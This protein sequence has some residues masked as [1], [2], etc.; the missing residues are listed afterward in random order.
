MFGQNIQ[1]GSQKKKKKLLF[2]DNTQQQQWNKIEYKITL[3]RRYH[4]WNKSLPS[5]RHTGHSRRLLLMLRWLL[6]KEKLRC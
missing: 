2:R 6:V 5:L 1:R 4:K 3:P